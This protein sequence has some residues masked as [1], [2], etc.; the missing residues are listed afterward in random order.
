MDRIIHILWKGKNEKKKNP[1]KIIFIG[2]YTLRIWIMKKCK[3]YNLQT[4]ITS[5]CKNKQYKHPENKLNCKGFENNTTK[6]IL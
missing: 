4:L 3:T 5:K 1:D 2:K 6:S